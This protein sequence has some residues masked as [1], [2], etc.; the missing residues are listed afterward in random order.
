MNP[1]DPAFRGSDLV[2]LTQPSHGLESR[3]DSRQ[4]DTFG[5]YRRP[6]S[7]IS[8]LLD[9]DRT[10]W[11]EGH[12]IDGF[13]APNLGDGSGLSNQLTRSYRQVG[14]SAHVV[15]FERLIGAL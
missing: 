3:A 8:R 14:G 10:R 1:D 2:P 13:T 12:D 15:L 9:L 5:L 4:P 11:N 6:S 7:Q